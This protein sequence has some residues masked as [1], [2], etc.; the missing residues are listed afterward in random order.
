MAKAK[1]AGQFAGGFF[2]NP[3]VIILGVAIA[4]IAFFRGDIRNAFASIGESFGSINISL[5]EINFP[6]FPEF[7]SFPSFTINQFPNAVLDEEGN[8][9]TL[10]L[11]QP[12]EGGLNPADAPTN[13]TPVDVALNPPEGVEPT[14]VGE[15]NPEAP[16]TSLFEFNPPGIV[17]FGVLGENLQGI[18]EET[19]TAAGIVPGTSFE[20]AMRLLEQFLAGDAVGVAVSPVSPEPTPTPEPTQE[21]AIVVGE[22]SALGGG[23]SFEGGVTT[24]SNLDEIVDTLTEVLQIFTSL[25]ASQARDVLTEFPDLTFGEFA[26]VDPDIINI[27]S[28]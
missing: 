19:A 9:V 25:T 27:G 11:T 5:P 26:Q 24:F 16:E 10:P 28:V 4:F 23:P 17:G 13:P 1:G 15:I 8:V 22:E 18:T 21:G 20:D 3:G 6:A 2:N 7:P 14:P 12:G